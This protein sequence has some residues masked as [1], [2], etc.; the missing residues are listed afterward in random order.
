[1][2]DTNVY[3]ESYRK[4]RK[5]DAS[6]FAAKFDPEA[7]GLLDLIWPDFLSDGGDANKRVICELYKLNVYGASMSSYTIRVS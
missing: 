4:A 3:D 1:M 2:N 7:S 6:D 5:M